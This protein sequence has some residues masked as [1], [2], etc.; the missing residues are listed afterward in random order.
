MKPKYSIIIATKNEEESIAKVIC[1]IPKNVEKKTEIIVPD[2]STD[3]TPIIASRLGAHVLK[4]KPGKGNAMR[5]AAKKSRGEILIFLDGDGTDPPQYIPKLLKKL[6]NS[7]LV[8]GSRAI[9]D[10]KEDDALMRQLFRVYNI[11]ASAG[12]KL[13][14]F[15]VKCDPLS[16]FRAIR[17][18]D[19][20]KLNLTST[21]FLIES[22]MNIKAM[23][24][25]FRIN[26]V[27][28]PHLKRGGGILNSKSI[29]DP[30]TWLKLIAY[31]MKNIGK[32]KKKGLIK[33]RNNIMKVI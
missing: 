6:E 26:V 22:E 29:T 3:S 16:G 18:K 20:V 2:A 30:K 11:F 32:N 5:T 15:N 7:N 9:K 21:D 12:F 10:F 13:A 17:K 33:I 23:D 24:N 25:R 8:L 4:T 19:W 14:G 28:I 1:S 27:P 31:I